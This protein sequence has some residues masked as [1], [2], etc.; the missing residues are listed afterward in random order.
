MIYDLI[1]VGFGPSN[2]ALSICI[3]EYNNQHKDKITACFLERQ[4]NFFWHKDMLLPNV[5]MQISFLK[6]LVTLRN[7]CSSFSFINYLYEKNRL[8]DFINLRRFY[9]TREEFHDYFIWAANKVSRLVH[10]RSDVVSI[11]LQSNL[12]CVSFIQNKTKKI[13]QYFCKNLVYAAGGIPKLPDF[14]SL[15][16]KNIIHSSQFLSAISQLNKLSPIN[17][18]VIGNGQS[19]AEIVH[20]LYNNFPNAKV[21]NI[22]K[23]YSYKQ[24]DD[25]P[26]VNQIFD[27]NQ[28]EFFQGLSS[29][30]KISIIQELSNTN[31]SVVDVDLIKSLYFIYYQEKVLGQQRLFLH[32][33]CEIVN[34]STKKE[35][36]VLSLKS[37]IKDIQKEINVDFIIFATGYNYQKNLKLLTSLD[38]YLSITEGKYCVMNNYSIKSVQLKDKIFL[39][40]FAE[41][42]HGLTDTLLSIISVKSNIILKTIINNLNKTKEFD[43]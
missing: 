13:K 16:Q 20:Y 2:L 26:F 41:Y 4:S 24:A 29:K 5:D 18:A 6:D 40:G 34:C 14:V 7:P 39:S 23:Q 22:F 30:S 32:N 43:L 11:D 27:T 9:T 1:G 36:I 38:E 35:H 37:M 42:H 17:F 15:N 19:A 28:V 10:Y 33:F 25:N 12:F 31:Y 3:E 21:N 8:E